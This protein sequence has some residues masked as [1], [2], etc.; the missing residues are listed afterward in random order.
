MSRSKGG[1]SWGPLWGETSELND[2]AQFLRDQITEAGLTLDQLRPAV[3]LAVSTISQRL[4]GKNLDRDF[5]SAVITACTDSPALAG[6]RDKRMELALRLWQKSTT[7]RTRLPQL[8]ATQTA[9]SVGELAVERGRVIE[10]YADNLELCRQMSTMQEQLNLVSSSAL[11]ARAAEQDAMKLTMVLSV[12]VWRLSDELERLKV[13]RDG[14]ITA[15]PVDQVRVQ[16][17]DSHLASVEMRQVRSRRDLDEANNKRERAFQVLTEAIGRRQM[18]T[19]NIRQ[20]A[21]VLEG[22]AVSTSAT[23]LVGRTQE[24][25]VEF[26][27]DEVD[28]ILDRL[29]QSARDLTD[30]IEDAAVDLEAATDLIDHGYPRPQQRNSDTADELKILGDTRE[31][32][33]RRAAAAGDP[34]AMYNLGV[35]FH[36]RDDLADAEMWYRKAADTGHPHAMNSLG[37]L[38]HQRSDLADAEMWYRKAADTGDTDAMNN[39]GWLFHQRD[40]LDDAETWYRTAADTGHTHAMYNLGWLFEQ[41]DELDDAETWYRTAADTGHTDAMY[42]LGWL[43]EQRDELDDAATWYGKAADTGHADA[44]YDLA[45]LLEQRDEL[46]D[47][48][49][50]YRKAADT[51]H[52][53]A[54]TNLAVRL[55]QR[56]ELAG[57][58]TWYRKAA[59]TGHADAMYDLAVLLE[60]RDELDDAATWYRKAADTGHTHAKTRLDAVL[61]KLGER[62][63]FDRS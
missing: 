18:L 51:G 27:L 32:Q 55:E 53:R 59:D 42:N 58:A 41:R 50:W 61:K 37:W 24:W 56:D 21:E 47:A 8:P 2:L 57:A 29:E 10:A 22:G 15:V 1:R 4:S 40:E 13:V 63:G 39:L 11:K 31:Y 7:S 34:D 49:T 60:Q 45:V 52:T 62:T 3:G 19:E 28:L 48:E 35:L 38:F 46:D 12:C 14:A 5:V 26:A 36:Q 6:T 44:M 23:E 30:Q 17:I 16:A 33:Y 9:Q 25:P 20:L 54:M 43:F